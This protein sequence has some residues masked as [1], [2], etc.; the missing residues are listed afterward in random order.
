MLRYYF[1]RRK[2]K[3]QLYLE[4]RE[5]EQKE[6]YHQAQ[7]RF[8]TNVSHDFRT[9]LSLIMAA[10]DSLKT[11]RTNIKYMNI[12]ENNIKRLHELVNE[13]LDFRALQNGKSSAGG[14]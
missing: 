14:E 8:F 13:L 11:G 7:L 5:R 2:L 6:E 3:M 10:F 4:E 12:L 1:E 9:P